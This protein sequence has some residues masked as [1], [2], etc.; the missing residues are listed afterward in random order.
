MPDEIRDYKSTTVL[1]ERGEG[2]DKK[3]FLR[4]HA[5]VFDDLSQNLGGFR[6]KIDPGAFDD[7]LN[8][9]VRAVFNHDPNFI[10]GR[11]EAGTLKISTDA[12]GLVYEVELPDTSQGRDLAVSIERGDITQSSFRFSVED[13]AWTEDDDG[14]TVRTIKKVA[15]LVDVSPVTY[16]AYLNADVGKRSLENFKKGKDSI[17]DRNALKLKLLKLSL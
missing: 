4:G 17:K 6:E 7:V 9:D 11:T 12:K 13:D 2:D 5:A 15:R 3:I 16:P 8:D 10:L 1:E 14:R